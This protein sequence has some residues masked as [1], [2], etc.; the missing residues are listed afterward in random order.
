MERKV[1]ETL[2]LGLQ[3]KLRRG[4]EAPKGR[5]AGDGIEI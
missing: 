1:Y 4:Y 5:L 2:G 3:P